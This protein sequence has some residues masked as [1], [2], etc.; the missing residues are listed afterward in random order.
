MTR[1]GP[2]QRLFSMFPN[3][4]P[5]CGLLLLRI[6][7]GLFVIHDGAAQ[8]SGSQQSSAILPLHAA[9]AIA[10]VL[11]MAGIW[12]PIAGALLGLIEIGILWCGTG[13]SEDAILSVAVALSIAMLGPGVWSVDAVAFGRQRL[14]FPE[15]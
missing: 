2:L 9:A 4:W 5:G 15:D 10:G 1:G 3:G 7:I 6:A 12:T 13:R 11:L 14:E 8:W